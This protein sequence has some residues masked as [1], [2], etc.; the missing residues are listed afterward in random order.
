MKRYSTFVSVAVGCMLVGL[1]TPVYGQTI[2]A[3]HLKRAEGY[4][5]LSQVPM[6]RDTQGRV[7]RLCL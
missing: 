7:I 6:E 5:T 4:F 1:G 2:D 3:E